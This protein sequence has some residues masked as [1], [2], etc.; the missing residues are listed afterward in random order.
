MDLFSSSRRRFH[1]QLLPVLMVALG[2]TSVVGAELPL[3][4]HPG[5]VIYKKMCLDCMREGRGR[6]G[7]VRRAAAW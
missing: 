4:E 3:P 1:A 7:Q 6:G 5:A 2:A